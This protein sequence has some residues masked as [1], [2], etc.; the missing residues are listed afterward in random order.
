MRFGKDKDVP[1]TDNILLRE[2][3]AS[4][5]GIPFQL[6]HLGAVRR[7]RVEIDKDKEGKA[8]QVRV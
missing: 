1:K 4:L 7:E 3:W 8:R 5:F 6:R 2:E